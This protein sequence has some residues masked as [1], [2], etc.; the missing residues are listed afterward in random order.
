MKITERLIKLTKILSHTILVS[1]KL[2]VSILLTPFV[3]LKTYKRKKASQLFS[4]HEKTLLFKA[5]QL[6]NHQG[7][8]NVAEIEDVITVAEK[9]EN[10]RVDY[11]ILKSF[12]QTDLT[13]SEFLKPQ[14]A[15]CCV[16]FDDLTEIEKYFEFKTNLP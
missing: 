11:Q 16:K 14:V 8:S 4:S 15:L 7:L 9:I 1:F 2:I 12:K 3:L 5:Q 13:F 6:L 10:A